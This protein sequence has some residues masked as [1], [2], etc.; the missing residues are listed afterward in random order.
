MRPA[1]NCSTNTGDPPTY[2]VVKCNILYNTIAYKLRRISLRRITAY[3]NKKI[4]SFPR[5]DQINF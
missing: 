5:N 4:G 3:L 1:C 2:T